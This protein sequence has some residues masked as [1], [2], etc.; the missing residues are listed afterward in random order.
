M[1]DI[2]DPENCKQCLK[3]FENLQKFLMHVTQSKACLGAHDPQLIKSLK[4]KSRIRT[5][6]NWYQQN[7]EELKKKRDSNKKASG[8]SCKYIPVSEKQSAAGKH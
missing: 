7:K 1:E 4:R 6:R 2:E 5:K 8:P 3:T